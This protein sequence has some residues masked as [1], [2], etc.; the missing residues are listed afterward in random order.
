MRFYHSIYS[1]FLLLYS[2]KY[3]PFY[4]DT[5]RISYCVLYILHISQ[6]QALLQFFL[7]TSKPEN[8][9][10]LLLLLLC[11]I[12]LLLLTSNQNLNVLM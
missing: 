12:E 11:N 3:I 1:E 2:S 6:F 4:T 5:A 7:Q 9:K 10:E 8:T